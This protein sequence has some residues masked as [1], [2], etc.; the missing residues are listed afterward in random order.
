MRL[1]ERLEN[2]AIGKW[3]PAGK[4]KKEL[5]EDAKKLEALC[6]DLYNN[7][8]IA[9]PSLTV[10]EDT[11]PYIEQFYKLGLLDKCDPDVV[12]AWVGEGGK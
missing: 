12:E 10:F 11:N 9:R 8:C 3:Y 1:S 6:F 2:L 7:L 5:A 4:A